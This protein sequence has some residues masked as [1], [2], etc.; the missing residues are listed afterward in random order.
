MSA[1]IF[2]KL[3][4]LDDAMAT[5]VEFGQRFATD[6]RVATSKLRLAELIQ[7]SRRPNRDTA[8]AEIFDDVIRTYPGTPEAFRALQLK[9][10]LDQ[11]NR[12]RVND[13]VL[14]IQVPR[15]LP[16]LRA[17]TEQFPTS[18]ASMDAFSRLA[19]MY[20]DLGKFDRAAQAY[21]DLA[22]NFPTNPNDAWFR[23]GEIYE[24]R[25]KDISKAREAYAK[26][27]AGTSRYRDA[28]RKLTRQP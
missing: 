3:G 10:R 27:P 7:R 24:R 19:D 4:R 20:G 12:Q 16:T 22:T 15:V 28:Q 5:H 2:E 6:R 26:V 14:G 8:S 9:I 11:G 25:L 23:A 13:P 1:D 17:L 18:P 21:V